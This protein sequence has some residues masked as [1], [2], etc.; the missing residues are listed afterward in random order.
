MGDNHS[1]WG[2]LAI[3][4]Y[5]LMMED[6]VRRQVALRGRRL[7]YFTIGWS[8]IEGLVA[9]IAGAIA[10]SISLVGFGIDSFIEVTS[11]GIAPASTTIAM[12]PQS[13]MVN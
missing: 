13:R 11:G 9:V 12:P 1:I 7:E 5:P 6:A 3:P 10:G 8:L 4:C 2:A